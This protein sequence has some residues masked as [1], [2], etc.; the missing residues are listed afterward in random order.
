MLK[1]TFNPEL[2][3]DVESVE[4][5]TIVHALRKMGNKLP[6]SEAMWFIESK[7]ARWNIFFRRGRHTMIYRGNEFVRESTHKEIDLMD[8]S[9]SAT[10]VVHTFAQYT[11]E[12]DYVATFSGELY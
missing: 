1:F 9:T 2:R 7:G 4:G 12:S 5:E 3:R 8:I 10:A 11:P 6:G